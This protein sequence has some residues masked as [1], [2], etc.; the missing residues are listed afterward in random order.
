MKRLF[1]FLL[2]LTLIGVT[3]PV[4]RANTAIDQDIGRFSL[5]AVAV[6]IKGSRQSFSYC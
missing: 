4:A 1:T 6:A 5:Y 2:A 3:M